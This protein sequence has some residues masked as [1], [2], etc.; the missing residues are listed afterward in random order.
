MAV[1]IGQTIGEAEYTTIRSGIVLVMGTPGGTGVGASG[2]NQSIASSAV[3]PGDKITAAAW[4]TLKT[5]IDKA[6]THQVGSAPSPALATVNTDSG[7]TKTI[8]DALETATNFIKD[9]G[10]RFTI[11]SGQSTT[12][13]AS[14]KTKTNW[15]GTQIHDITFT[16][17]SANAVKAFFN[18]GGKLVLSSTL[19]YTG[20]EAKTLDWQS[21]V[22]GPGVVTM[23]HVSVSKTGASG[24]VINDGYYDLDTTARY[25]VSKTGTNPYS[26]NDYQI[27]ARSSTNG[28]R[29]RLIY[30]DDDAGDQTGL[31]PAVDE[32]VKGTLTSALSYIRPTGSNVQTT[33]PTIAFGATNTFT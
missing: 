21:T 7:I 33:A 17:A 18:A 15:N 12:V 31:G 27:E 19:S 2:Y 24:T 1:T 5:D 32:N 29:I 28:V 23:N 16:W 6:Y 20:S 14:S 9:A 11:G 13:S 4:N 8:H 26:E 25:L 10:N 22:A 3:S 30:R